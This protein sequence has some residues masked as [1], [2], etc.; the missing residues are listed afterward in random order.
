MARP[1]KKGLDYFP[2]DVNLF[3]DLK[4]RFLMG[5]FGADGLAVYIYLLTAIYREGYCV[6]ADE[7]FRLLVCVDLRLRADRLEE[8]FSF[9]LERGLFDAALYREQ[10]VL[11]SAGIQRRFQEAVKAR[12]SRRGIPVEARWWL[13]SDEETAAYIRRE[14]AGASGT[15]SP[16]QERATKP[17]KRKAPLPAPDRAEL[18]AQYGAQ[19]VDAYLAKAAAYGRTGDQALRS[20]A[21]WLAEDALS[22]KIKA[23]RPT[24]LDVDAYTDMVKGFRP[25]FVQKEETE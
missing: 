20:A 15:G 19:L 11:T 1:L 18:T 10:G 22:G 14:E 7:D 5:K 13:L 4:I 24:S 6:R 23:P 9:F 12:S 3:S 8:M 21:R 25:R 16:E 17:E 2:M